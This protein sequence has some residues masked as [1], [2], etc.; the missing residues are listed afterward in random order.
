MIFTILL[1][2]MYYLFD[3]V[4]FISR[5]QS[6]KV[7]KYFSFSLFIYSLCVSAPLRLCV[8]FKRK[9]V[10]TPPGGGKGGGAFPWGRTG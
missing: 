7:A 9:S 5:T 4:L 1:F 8:L 3:Y 6:R 10:S 2:T